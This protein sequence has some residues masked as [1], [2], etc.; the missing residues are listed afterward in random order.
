MLP[1]RFG[2]VN[3]LS[4]NKHPLFMSILGYTFCYLSVYYDHA[5]SWNGAL[6]IDNRRKF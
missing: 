2:S 4:K 3:A 5:L 1:A 6:T